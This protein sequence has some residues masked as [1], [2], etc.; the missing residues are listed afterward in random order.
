MSARPIVWTCSNLRSCL[1]FVDLPPFV[2]LQ[3]P[4]CSRRNRCAV[5]SGSDEEG[6]P[7]AFRGYPGVLN[8]IMANVGE[9]G[10]DERKI[11]SGNGNGS[12]GG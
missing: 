6:S 8:R 7:V 4:A 11:D 3:L 12:V 9:D 5:Y 1:L 10:E 2:M